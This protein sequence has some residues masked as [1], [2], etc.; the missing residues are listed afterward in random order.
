M[1]HI[2]IP[3]DFNLLKKIQRE[4]QTDNVLYKPGPYWMNK[5]RNSVF[6]IK[7]KGLSNFRG[8][9]NGATTSFGD[10]PLIDFRTQLNTSALNSLFGHAI[11]LLAPFKMAFDEARSIAKVQF[12][13]GLVYKNKIR[14]NDKRVASL[15]SKYSPLLH[16]L[17]GNP[18]DVIEMQNGEKFSNHYL[19]LIYS[20]EAF[21]DSAG[22]A[23]ANSFMEIGGG[24]GA[25]IHI[26]I[27]RYPNIKK[28]LY[29]DISPN[30]YVAVQYL[31]ALYGNSVRYASSEFHSKISFSESDELEI[32]CLLPS[33]IENVNASVDIFW[34]AH[35]FVEM[36]K[37]VVANYARHLLRFRPQRGMRICL[38]SYDCF[39]LDTT[40]HPSELSNLFNVDFAVESVSTLNPDRCNF[41]LYANNLN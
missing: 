28:F 6:E 19:D 3:D 12:E 8:F 14:M 23:T 9:D 11:N 33:S 39:D 7:R 21:D 40:F 20:Q 25:N 10:N 37:E 41:H 26:L 13:F 18:V 1:E 15:I 4:S 32:I 2:E 24:F 27:E 16:T 35:S 34:N 30:L 31:K 36:P 5:T 17:L 38:L 22:F 29:V